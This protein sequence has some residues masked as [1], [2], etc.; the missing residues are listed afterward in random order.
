LAI[1]AFY[2]IPQA[3]PL[4]AVKSLELRSLGRA[5][6][7]HPSLKTALPVEVLPESALLE[8]PRSLEAWAMDFLRTMPIPRPSA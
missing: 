2:S 3:L 8:P 5:H 4:V 1:F 6:G 7:V